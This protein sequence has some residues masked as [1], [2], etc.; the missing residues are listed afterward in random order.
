MSRGHV[1]YK[2]DAPVPATDADNDHV[3]RTSSTRVFVTVFL[4]LA[5][6]FALTSQGDVNRLSPDPIAAAAAAW[7][8]AEHATLDLSGQT[9]PDN[10]WL[11]EHDGKVLS[12]RTPGVIAFGIPAALVGS[13]VSDGFSLWPE[14][15]TG[16]L[17]SAGAAGLL[18][19]LLLE[20]GATARQAVSFA[21]LGALAT[22]TWAVSSDGLWTHGPDQLLLTGALLACARRNLWW[23]GALL[24]AAATVRLHLVVVSLVLGVGLAWSRRSLRP[25]SAFGLPAIAGVIAVVTYG[26]VV[27]GLWSLAPGYAAVGQPTTANVLG[28]GASGPGGSV[29]LADAINVLGALF[30]PDRGLFLV[31]PVVLVLLLRARDGWRSTPDFARWAALGG[32]AYFLVQM[33]LNHFTG[34]LHFYGYRLV[35]EPLTCWPRSCG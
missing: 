10:P 1:T 18:A 12:N 15:L 20:L 7:S 35:L 28:S 14:R 19:L 9:L 30:S 34:G 16:A 17:T 32:L 25:L 11:L 8:V 3:D 24:G 26:K 5:L 22:G 33:R 6:L 4:P 23:A 31:S 27:F 29:P 2:R 21:L 13:T